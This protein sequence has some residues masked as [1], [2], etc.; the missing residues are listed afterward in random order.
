ML[1]GAMNHPAHRVVDEIEWMAA[2]G[3]DF[4]D[5]TLEPP[6]A[7]PR[8]L[9]V[10]SVRA[11]L[12]RRGLRVVGHTAYYLPFASPFESIR[13]A[14]VEEAKR[15]LEVFSKLGVAWMNVHPDGH[16]PMHDKS[17]VLERNTG[18]FIPEGATQTIPN[19]VSLDLSNLPGNEAHFNPNS[20]CSIGSMTLTNT[21]GTQKR[22]T[23]TP[24]TGKVKIE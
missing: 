18:G 10:R 1:I 11:A 20:T 17:Y 14:A 8:D 13:R 22:I 23:L 9:D 2:M 7:A 5:L 16:V 4:I 6:L 24:A 21:K 12:D 3:L 15:C 19:G